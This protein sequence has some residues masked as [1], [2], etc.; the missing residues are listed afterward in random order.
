[1]SF[2]L[3][4]YKDYNRSE[5][6]LFMKKSWRILIEMN[7][8][9]HRSLTEVSIKNANNIIEGVGLIKTFL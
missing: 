2:F 6:E 8:L 1:M 3:N 5:L 4:F 9:L 7:S